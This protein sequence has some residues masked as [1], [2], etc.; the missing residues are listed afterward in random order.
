MTFCYSKCSCFLKAKLV[1]QEDT[2]KHPVLHCPGFHYL[3]MSS[4]PTKEVDVLKA[5]ATIK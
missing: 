2:K 5:V 1:V 3:C 4:V